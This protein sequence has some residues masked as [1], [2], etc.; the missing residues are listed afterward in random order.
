MA[1]HHTRQIPKLSAE[2]RRTLEYWARCSTTGEAMAL[3]ARI[4]LGSAAGSS[5]AAL[6][7][8][9][10]STRATVGKWRRRFL[11]RGMEGLLDEPRS[12]AP[13]RIGDAEV[14]FVVRETLESPRPGAGRW[15]TRSMA[16]RCGTSSSTVARIW[17]DF[18][19]QPHRDEMFELCLEPEFEP[20]VR[21]ILGLY[22]HPPERAVVVCA[23][24]RSQTDAMDPAR[25]TP[26]AR[27]GLPE[28]RT[29]DRR[30][31][32][33]ISQIRELDIAT[34]QA[35][36]EWSERHRA[37]D[38]RKFLT[39]IG[40]VV[41]AGLEFHLVL[42]N[43]GTH[44]AAMIHDW[45]AASPRFHLHLTG[46]SG[47]WISQVEH[48]YANLPEPRGRHGKARGTQGLEE[49]IEGY[50]AAQI[51][52]QKPFIWAKSADQIVDSLENDAQILLRQ[53][54]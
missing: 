41:P 49:A 17:Q 30:R 10:D 19:L 21:D 29:D 11:D 27:P 52:N 33:A 13:R 44:K 38:F 4:V 15:S 9:L 3:R 22:L 39:G 36:V 20:Q 32:R 45:L 14:E 18:A 23:A 46:T 2:D 51:Q 42:D 12:G 47:A 48:W 8:E 53:E 43:F 28:G 7:E 35:A 26:S 6:A 40:M 54:A 16:D 50:L 31:L 37:V 24:E 5:D 25:P 34:N 1:N